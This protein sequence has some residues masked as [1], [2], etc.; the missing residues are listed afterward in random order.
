MLTSIGVY[1]IYLV[2]GYPSILLSVYDISIHIESHLE[3]GE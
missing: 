1:D 3:G 2:N